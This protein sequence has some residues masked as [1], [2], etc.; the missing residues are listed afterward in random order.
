MAN[1]GQN[2]HPP[3]AQAR[4]KAKAQPQKFVKPQLQLIIQNLEDAGSRKFQENF[5]ATE[6]MRTAI[7][8]V[9]T[10]MFSPLA[11]FRSNKG[12]HLEHNALVMDSR[13]QEDD[14]ESDDD[15]DDGT[16]KEVSVWLLS[17]S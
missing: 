12:S 7:T 4:P 10:T 14:W 17:Q 2:N 5:L 16:W 3:A 11:P 9:W 13:E 15:V 1:R 8:K 6:L